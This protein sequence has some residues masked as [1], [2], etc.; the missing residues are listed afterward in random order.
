MHSRFALMTRDAPLP[1]GS[2]RTRTKILTTWFEVR[3]Q[4]IKDG[5]SVEEVEVQ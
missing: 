5:V 2:N 3:D 1:A 4:R